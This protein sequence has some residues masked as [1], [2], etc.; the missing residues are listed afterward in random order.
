MIW[1]KQY[2]LQVLYLTKHYEWENIEC[3]IDISFCFEASRVS[4][5]EKWCGMLIICETKILNV[6]TD[7]LS[8]YSVNELDIVETLFGFQ[9]GT[10]DLFISPKRPIHALSKSDSTPRLCLNGV[11]TDISMP[12]GKCIGRICANKMLTRCNRGF[13]CRSYCLHNMFR[14]PLWPSSGVQEYYT[15]VA[16]CGIW[17]CKNVKK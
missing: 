16:A 3:K 5:R 1:H 9:R 12:F 6:E 14:A 2:S 11:H 17:C 4:S 15:V 8:Q 10:R 7:Q 13:Y